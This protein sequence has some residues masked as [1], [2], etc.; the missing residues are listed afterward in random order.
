MVLL[1]MRADALSTLATAGAFG[2]V[3]LAVHSYATCSSGEERGE[4]RFAN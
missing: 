4:T 3:P 1:L 2:V